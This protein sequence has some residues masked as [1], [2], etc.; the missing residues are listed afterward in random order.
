MSRRDVPLCDNWS[1]PAWVSCAHAVGRSGAYAAADTTGMEIETRHV[2]PGK[3][4][5]RDYRRDK[6]RPWLTTA[7]PASAQHPEPRPDVVAKL[8]KGG[9]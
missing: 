9:A 7:F 5:C 2:L 3:D 1:C 4:S 8:K 6:P